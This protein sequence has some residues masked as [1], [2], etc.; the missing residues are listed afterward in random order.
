MNDAD[1]KIT[2]PRYIEAQHLILHN[3]DNIIPIQRLLST[4][5]ID[6]LTCK[7]SLN[8]KIFDKV[9]AINCNINTLRLIGCGP[10]DEIDI[11][12]NDKLIQ[13]LNLHRKLVNLTIEAVTKAYI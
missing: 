13:S 12:D 4:I 2:G 6:T 5:N 1:A 7:Y 9:T 10:Y 3:V 11:F 8:M